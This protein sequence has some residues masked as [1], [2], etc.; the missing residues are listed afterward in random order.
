MIKDSSVKQ[1]AREIKKANKNQIHEQKKQIGTGFISFG[2]LAFAS[3]V[4][5]QIFEN[6]FIDIKW[7]IALT[8]VILFII[9]YIVAY[10]V[11]K[12]EE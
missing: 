10:L 4:F 7:E 8:G 11:L 6:T 1:I 9:T 12:R 2:N 3:L 5:G